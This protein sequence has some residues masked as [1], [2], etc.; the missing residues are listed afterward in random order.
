MAYNVDIYT[1]KSLTVTDRH[2]VAA[3]A[4]LKRH[5]WIQPFRKS[6]FERFQVIQKYNYYK[7]FDLH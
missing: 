5:L 7:S 3:A 1:G 6:T 2:C 4:L